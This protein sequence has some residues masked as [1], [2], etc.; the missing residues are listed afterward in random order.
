MNRLF[1]IT[2]QDGTVFEKELFC[3][4]LWFGHRQVKNDYPN[5]IKAE[6]IKDIY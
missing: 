5:V 1:R 6:H 4:Q 3:I 2:L